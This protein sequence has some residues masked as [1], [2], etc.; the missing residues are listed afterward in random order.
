MFDYEFLVVGALV[1]TDY[2]YG[3]EAMRVLTVSDAEPVA[4]TDV[5]ARYFNTRTGTFET[6][7]FKGFELRPA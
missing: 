7:A 4:G 6:A 1:F 2:P 5:T 3:P